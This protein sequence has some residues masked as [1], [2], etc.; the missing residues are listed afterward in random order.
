[1]ICSFYSSTLSPRGR[2]KRHRE[3]QKPQAFPAPS[4]G[5]AGLF[6][7]ELGAAWDEYLWI[8]M[9]MSVFLLVVSE[10]IT[11]LM[12]MVHVVFRHI[13]LA[14]YQAHKNDKRM[15]YTFYHVE[16]FSK[17]WSGTRCVVVGSN[18]AIRCIKDALAPAHPAA[19]S[20]RLS[21]SVM[22]PHRI[23]NQNQIHPNFQWTSFNQLIFPPFSTYRD[24]KQ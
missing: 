20:A 8:I 6:G 22:V 9:F 4:C 11:I 21:P 7:F 10:A 23:R 2:S 24:Q 17:S 15:E 19:V 12:W 18:E 5:P 1:M 14:T 13:M 3:N 16:S